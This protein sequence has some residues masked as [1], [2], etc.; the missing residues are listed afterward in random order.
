[1]YLGG[2]AIIFKRL[3]SQPKAVKET[4]YDHKMSDFISSVVLAVALLT[5]LFMLLGNNDE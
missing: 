5:M 3:S 4:Q 2:W 1:V